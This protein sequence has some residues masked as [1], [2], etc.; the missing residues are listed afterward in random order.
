MIACVQVQLRN[1]HDH[2][3]PRP[4]QIFPINIDGI[5]TGLEFLQGLTL[6]PNVIIQLPSVSLGKRA[7]VPG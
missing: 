5:S 7:K 4:I 2:I 1:I 3:Q 6:S